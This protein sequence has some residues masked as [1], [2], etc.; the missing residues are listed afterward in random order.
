MRAVELG[1]LPQWHGKEEQTAALMGRL[2]F[3]G[4]VNPLHAAKL[5]ARLIRAL[6]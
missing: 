6:R 5:K 4:A 3:V 2:A 1:R